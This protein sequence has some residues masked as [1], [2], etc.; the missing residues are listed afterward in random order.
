M[1]LQAQE[2]QFSGIIQDS[3]QNPIAHAN[4]IATPQDSI[5]QTT[6][7]ITNQQGK[8]KLD[9][10]ANK[11]YTLKITHLAFGKQID[12][13]IIT[14]SETKNYTLFERTESLEEVV[15]EQE[16][17]V[18]V[19]E[20]T[21]RYKVDQ[22][23]TGDE[24]KLRDI[25]K[26]LPGVEVDR[27][28]N[29]KVNG[30]EVKK[31][32]IEG[33]EFFTGDPKLGVNNIPADAIK[34]IEALDNNPEITMLK[35]LDDS[36]RMVLNI[37]LKEG[38][39]NFMFG[40]SEVG[41]GIKERYYVNPNIFYYS[42]NRSIN[43]LADLNNTGESAFSYSDL[44]DF[45]GGFYS[46]RGTQNKFATQP[47]ASLFSGNNGFSNK[48]KLGAA[49]WSER[50]AKYLRLDA[51]VIVK[52]VFTESK[53]IQEINY[54]SQEQEDEYRENEEKNDQFFSL[55]KVKLRYDNLKDWDLQT[56]F[57]VKYAD[58]VA[59]EQTVSIT[60]NENIFFNDVNDINSFSLSN[61]NS[62]NKKFSYKH[63]L[64]INTNFEYN[65]K[66][67]NYDWLF[68]QP[69]FNEIIPIEETESG[70]INLLKDNSSYSQLFQV[71][72]KH[73]WILNNTNHLYPTAGINYL[74]KD[75]NT[76]EYQ[77][78]D[79][80]NLINFQDAGFNNQL[81]F[82]LIDAFGGFQYK[83]M[84]G[85]WITRLGAFTHLYSWQAKQFNT[86]IVNHQKMIFLPEVMVKWDIN[87]VESFRLDYRLNSTFADA[88]KFANRFQLTNFNSIYQGNENLENELY[89]D[90]DISYRNYNFYSKINY[91]IN[92]SYLGREQSIR[93][94]TQLDGIS[95][96][97]T[98]ILNSLPEN[99]YS[100]YVSI[101]K[102]FKSDLTLSVNGNVYLND[103]ARLVNEERL[104]YKSKSYSYSAKGKYYK[105]NFPTIEIAFQQSFNV[106]SSEDQEATRFTQLNPSATIKYR[107]FKDFLLESDYKYTYYINQNT[108]ESSEFQIG[109]AS[110]RYK[111]E[112]SA[113]GFGVEVSN[114]FDV[115]FKR[116]NSTSNFLI[117][118]QRT[119]LQPRIL[120]LKVTYQL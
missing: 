101:S 8:Y 105:K 58:A 33:Q 66:K 89:H 51:Y 9:L 75:F 21:I 117:S 22:F 13:V 18:V 93:E 54:I 47:S 60:N 90:V 40:E 80:E 73:Y 11:N 63:T 115:N 20:D 57:L 30:K 92:L 110:L 108:N 74:K 24:R 45:E 85:K 26:K 32:M 120:L 64:S 111:Q 6:F 59:R 113:W 3:M 41:G 39:K 28:G 83:T 36:Q 23:K 79:N 114:I 78:L 82:K 27:E 14:K 96:I 62:I 91:N 100:G 71:D 53:T 112:S 68:N 102:R 119:L 77:K 1:S 87:K 76:F 72:A 84:F 70:D 10:I 46:L 44:I 2:V 38:K 118:D 98:S 81:D 67:N 61:V 56:N 34:E 106:F 116:N 43:V 107:F 35:G 12:T 16:M 55:G 109:N 52:D 95:Y 17:A 88:E 25:L 4:V 31:L 50:L 97:N 42:P 5:L 99:S 65:E 15:I 104:D 7:S 49:S 29:V 19:K 103:Y 86:E 48:N 37:K 69:I 94:T